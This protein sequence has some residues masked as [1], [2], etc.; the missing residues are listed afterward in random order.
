[1]S[2]LVPGLL[3]LRGLRRQWNRLSDKTWQETCQDFSTRSQ[4]MHS[5]VDETQLRIS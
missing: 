4:L 1:M 2:I 5:I 3:T